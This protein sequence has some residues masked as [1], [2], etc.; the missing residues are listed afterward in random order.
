MMPIRIHYRGI[1]SILTGIDRRQVFGKA[2]KS[3]LFLIKSR[4]CRFKTG[5]FETA[6]VTSKEKEIYE[7]F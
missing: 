1:L 5:R 7:V 6:L 3:P 2:G 4:G